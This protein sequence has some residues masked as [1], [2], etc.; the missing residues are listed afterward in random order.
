MKAARFHAKEDVRIDDIEEPTPGPGEVKIR[1][2][3]S[4]ICGSDLHI[5]FAPEAAGVNFDEPH[6]LT[7]SLPP[8]V[9][10]HEFSGTVA[11][12]GEGVDS[13]RVGDRVAVWPIYYCG[14]CPACEKGMVNVC[15]FISFHGVMSNGGGMAEYTTIA[16]SKLHVLPDNVD[17]RMGALVE[18]MAVA[19]HA[20]ERSGIQAGQTALIAGAGPI[21]IGVWFA[22]RARG[23][24]T[25]IV[26]EP[27]SERRA[28]I[29]GVGATTVVNPAEEDLTA[30]VQAETGGR[31]V[32]VAFDAAGVAPAVASALTELTPGG[33]VIVVAIHERPIELLPT[34]LVMSETGIQGT[35][36]YLQSDFDAVIKAMS[37][38]GYTAEGWVSEVPLEGVVEAITDLRAGKRMKVLVQSGE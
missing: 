9:L 27:S 4:G 21:G 33:Q 12:L 24:E 11:E 22:L 34:Q 2:A 19:W 17:L 3:Y 36:G 28:A 7:G 6:P 31:G 20:V 23:V 10:G 38:G 25:V 18:P 1:N 29:Q 14:E 5:Y 30:R 13:V 35:L 16:A 26:S 32:D 8:Q 15:R 37:E